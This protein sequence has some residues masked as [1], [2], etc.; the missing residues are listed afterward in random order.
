MMSGVRIEMKLLMGS[1][2]K[3]CPTKSEPPRRM[4]LNHVSDL[5]PENRNRKQS[6]HEENRPRRV[7]ISGR[8]RKRPSCVMSSV[9]FVPIPSFSSSLSTSLLL[10]LP[11]LFIMDLQIGFSIQRGGERYIVPHYLVMPLNMVDQTGRPLSLK[12]FQGLGYLLR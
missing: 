8:R 4:Q 6:H 5:I 11:L 1:Y 12:P 9:R 2:V 10:L 7:A 3:I